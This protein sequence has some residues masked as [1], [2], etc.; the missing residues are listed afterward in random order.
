MAPHRQREGGNLPPCNQRRIPEA[1]KASPEG[2]H[3]IPKGANRPRTI[4]MGP[5]DG[6]IHP[7]TTNSQGFPM[8]I[9]TEKDSLGERSIPADAY[10]G[11]QTHRA[12]ENFRSEEHTSELQP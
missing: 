9:R 7:Q 11:V 6:P 3:R 4:R 2:G 5:V 12:I 10:Y 1:K 8:N